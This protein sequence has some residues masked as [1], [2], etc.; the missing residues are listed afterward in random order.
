MG[1]VVQVAYQ[2]FLFRE[3]CGSVLLGGSGLLFSG[4]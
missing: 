3:A 2:V 4:V 1:G